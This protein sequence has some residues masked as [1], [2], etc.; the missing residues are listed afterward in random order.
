MTVN[1]VTIIVKAMIVTL[2]SENANRHN[3]Y[4]SKEGKCSVWHMNGRRDKVGSFSFH[5]EIEPK[6]QKSKN[7]LKFFKP[8]IT[9]EIAEL[10]STET[11]NVHIIS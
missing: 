9:W 10:I 7:P 8:F 5:W 6:C 2:S 4:E 3:S 11:M 1:S